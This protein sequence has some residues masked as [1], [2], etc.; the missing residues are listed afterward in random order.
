MELTVKI[1]KKPDDLS[2]CYKVRYEVFIDEQ[3]FDEE[4][5]LDEFDDIAHHVLI[6]DGSSPIAT[7]RVF[8]NNEYW[9]IGRVCVLQKYRGKKL[10]NLLLENIEMHLQALN[11]DEVY[12]ASQYHAKDF[13]FKFGYEQ[14]GEVFLEEGCEHI[15]MVKK[16]GK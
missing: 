14:V 16:I 13:Y 8:Y 4:I 1:L 11:V 12:L 15:K 7:A 6:C 9:K 5:E 10:G 2:L 3:G